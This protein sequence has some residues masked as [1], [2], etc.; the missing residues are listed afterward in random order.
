VVGCGLD[1]DALGAR[2]LS[3]STIGGGDLA[4]GVL[5]GS[6]RSFSTTGSGVPGMGTD[7]GDGSIPWAAA[8]TCARAAVAATRLNIEDV[9]LNVLMHHA[10]ADDQALWRLVVVTIQFKDELVFK[11]KRC[12]RPKS[13][14]T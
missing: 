1:S 2:D 12:H 10:A 13:G 6:G 9:P 11:G 7:D 5:G 8:T 4:L 14:S 3:T